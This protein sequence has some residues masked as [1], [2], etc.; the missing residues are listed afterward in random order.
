MERDLSPPNLE[1]EKEIWAKGRIPA[2]VDEAGRGPLAGPVV[3]AA[4]VLP[5]DCK[6]E[7]LDDSKKLSHSKRE[8]I[9]EEIKS[10]A[11]S[12]AIG[13]VEPEEIDKINILR[14]S[15]LAMEISVKQLTTKPDYLLIDGNQKTS[16]LLM[17]ETIVKG[18]SKSCSIA[19]ASILA[20][21]TR[22]SI[23]EEY[24]SIYPEYN[25]KGH[26]GYPTKEHY[27]ALR[28]YG[29]CPIHRKTFRGVL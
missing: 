25:F 6:I 12:Y 20:K 29:P 18:D 7:G 28:E 27:Q 14:A 15:L 4:V 2:G 8:K 13:I 10:I 3:A 22:D 1:F 24:H 19:A 21:V 26:K 17:Q 5:D 9:L 16:L 23:M 11:I